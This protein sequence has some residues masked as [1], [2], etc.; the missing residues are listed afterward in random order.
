MERKQQDHFLGVRLTN[1]REVFS[2]NSLLL[3]FLVGVAAFF[4]C[5]IVLAR[6]GSLHVGVGV[7]W[8]GRRLGSPGGCWL[9]WALSWLPSP[10]MWGG[11][12]RLFGVYVG[13]I[14]P[15]KLLGC[16]TCMFFKWIV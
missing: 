11:V 7:G 8:C 14:L 2:P 5:E 16:F 3:W 4:G 1:I 12:L 15:G 13:V 6:F 10:F 9:V